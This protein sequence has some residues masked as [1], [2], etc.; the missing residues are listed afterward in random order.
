[1]NTKEMEQGY[2]IFFKSQIAFEHNKINN[3][4]YF[5]L[6]LFKDLTQRSFYENFHMLINQKF[7]LIF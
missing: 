1:M 4:I 5:Y 2:G 6:Y 3:K 7:N